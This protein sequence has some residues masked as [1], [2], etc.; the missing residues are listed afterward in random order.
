LRLWQHA[1]LECFVNHRQPDFLA[2]ATPG[3]GKTTFALVAARMALAEQPARVVVVTPTAHLKTQW[4]QAAAGLDLHLDPAWSAADGGLPTDMHG[5]VTTYHQVAL[6]PGVVLRLARRAFVILD[7]VHHGGEDR[8][9]GAGLQ[10]AFGGAAC[11]LSLSG[12]PFAAIRKP[13]RSCATRATKPY[14]TSNTA[15]PTRC[16]TGRWYARCTFRWSAG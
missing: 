7:E 1:A 15:M 3:A 6:D 5:V 13:S 10:A 16:G 11:R 8:A 14:R 2:V 9:W 12:T 4:A